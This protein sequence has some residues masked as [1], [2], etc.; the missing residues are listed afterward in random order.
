[1][2]G[3]DTQLPS[4]NGPAVQFMP[5][6]AGARDTF[7]QESANA[8][9]DGAR[10]TAAMTAPLNSNFLKHMPP[11]E[12]SP[13]GLPGSQPMAKDGVKAEAYAKRLCTPARANGGWL[14]PRWR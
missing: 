7:D 4:V 13:D 6:G 1:M 12:P 10:T 9:A 11:L 5:Q 8:V 14:R 3:S 2:L